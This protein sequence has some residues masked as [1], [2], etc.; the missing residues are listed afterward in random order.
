MTFGRPARSVRLM[1]SLP[2]PERKGAHIRTLP[3]LWHS[4]GHLPCLWL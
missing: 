4:L 3:M 1:R 2:P